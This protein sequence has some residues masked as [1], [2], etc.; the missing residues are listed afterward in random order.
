MMED[1]GVNLVVTSN[2]GAHL[3]R[4]ENSQQVSTVLLAHGELYIT[5]LQNWAHRVHGSVAYA[6]IP[7]L[8]SSHELIITQS[9]NLD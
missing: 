1:L 4:L 7:M 5:R 9:L 8:R 3:Q 2:F 6:L